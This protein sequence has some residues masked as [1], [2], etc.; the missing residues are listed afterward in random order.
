[1]SNNGLLG[2]VPIAIKQ[3]QKQPIQTI[4]FSG[5]ISSILDI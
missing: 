1:M 4:P 2:F 5:F 3:N